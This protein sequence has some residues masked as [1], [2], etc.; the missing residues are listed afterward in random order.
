MELTERTIIDHLKKN[1]FKINIHWVLF[2]RLLG[3]TLDEIWSSEQSSYRDNYT[4]LALEDCLSKLLNN[5][6]TCSWEKVNTAM[7]KLKTERKL[8][9]LF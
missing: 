6:E 2:M 5:D 7:N 1:E 3:L 9:T 4:E 8:F